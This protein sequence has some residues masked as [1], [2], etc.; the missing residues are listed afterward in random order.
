MFYVF[1][2]FF[3]TTEAYGYTVCQ[4]IDLNTAIYTVNEHNESNKL[5]LYLFERVQ[6]D[7]YFTLFF[8][9]IAA[10]LQRNFFQGHRKKGYDCFGYF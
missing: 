6:I 9:R 1:H 10:K 7:T 5:I 2:F 3:V 4:Y 8:P